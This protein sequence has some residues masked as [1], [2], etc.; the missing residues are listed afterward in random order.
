MDYKELVFQGDVKYYKE[1]S[2]VNYKKKTQINITIDSLDLNTFD[3]I[4][5]F[6]IPLKDEN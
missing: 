6:N 1:I 4:S 2:I 5:I 3:D